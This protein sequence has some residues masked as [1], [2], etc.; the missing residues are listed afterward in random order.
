[1]P[2]NPLPEPGSLAS[3]HG[4]LGHRTGSLAF[5]DGKQ[6]HQPGPGMFGIYVRHHALPFNA[7]HTMYNIL[8]VN[9]H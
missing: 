6:V 5:V 4:E 7:S 1:M 3:V 9:F 2:D 8:G